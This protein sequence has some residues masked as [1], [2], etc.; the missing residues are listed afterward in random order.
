MSIGRQNSLRIL[1]YGHDAVLLQTRC[2]VLRNAGFQVDAAHSEDELETYMTEAQVP[3]DLLLLGHTIPDTALPRIMTNAADSSTL[4]H[5]L[6]GPVD[7]RQLIR[8]LS[9]R[10]NGG[11]AVVDPD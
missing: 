11:A 1:A 5:R 2:M 10:L 6:S 4:V 3:Y 8:E 9:D 7:P